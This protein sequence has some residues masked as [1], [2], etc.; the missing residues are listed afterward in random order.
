MLSFA[1]WEM[2][3]NLNGSIV[4]QSHS[5]KEIFCIDITWMHL[6]YVLS[7]LLHIESIHK[8]ALNWKQFTYTSYKF[9][10]EYQIPGIVVKQAMVYF[11]D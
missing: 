2:A 7:M 1:L 5:G 9:V 11:H 6:K 4:Q 10:R 3:M 8:G